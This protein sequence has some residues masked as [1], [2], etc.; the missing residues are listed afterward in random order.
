LQF[1]KTFQNQNVK[2]LSAMVNLLKQSKE[3]C[4]TVVR[5]QNGQNRATW[6]GLECRE[7]YDE[8]VPVQSVTRQCLLPPASLQDPTAIAIMIIQTFL[9]HIMC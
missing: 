6:W 8:H 9:I 3:I 4:Q 2:Q 1:S 5:N 7:V